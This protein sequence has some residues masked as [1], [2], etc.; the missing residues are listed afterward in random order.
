MIECKTMQEALGV[1]NVAHIVLG[2][3]IRAYQYGDELPPP[4]PP[5]TEEDIE[6]SARAELDEDKLLKALVIRMMEVRLGRLPTATEA[7]AERD[8]IAQ[9]YRNL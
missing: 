6:A 8:R 9:I 1:S 3:P 2:N 5:P 7:R 4:L